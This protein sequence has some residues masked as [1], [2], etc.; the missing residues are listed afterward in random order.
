MRQ[1][2]RLSNGKR[3]ANFSSPHVFT[4]EDG[5]VMPAV[6][7]EESKRL[8]LVIEEDEINDKG[9]IMIEHTLSRDIEIEVDFW[10]EQHEQGNVDVVFCPFPMIQALWHNVRNNLHAPQEYMES[11]PFRSVWTVDRVTKAISISKQCL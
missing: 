2:I 1:I 6:S 11:M 10:K 8:S 4:F 3:V 7:V 5:T 9:D